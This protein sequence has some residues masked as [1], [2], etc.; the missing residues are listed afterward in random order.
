MGACRLLG[1][2][3]IIGQPLRA[4]QITFPAAAEA[5][6]TSLRALRYGFPRLG[7]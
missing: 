2:R 3:H 5:I 1:N 7:R 6:F 4:T